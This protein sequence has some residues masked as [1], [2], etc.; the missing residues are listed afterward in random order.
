M[1]IYYIRVRP[2]C[3]AFFY[4][5]SNFCIDKF[6]LNAERVANKIQKIKH[7]NCIKWDLS[8]KSNRERWAA[9]TTSRLLSPQIDLWHGEN[10]GYKGVLMQS[11]A[12]RQAFCINCVQIHPKA[13][14]GAQ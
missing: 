11:S 1:N 3:W 4:F 9:S 14:V 5:I 12:R 6:F 2:R 13:S 7:A 8:R 10:E